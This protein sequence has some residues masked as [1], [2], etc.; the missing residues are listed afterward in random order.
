MTK[1]ATQHDFFVVPAKE[2]ERGEWLVISEQDE[3]IS[4]ESVSSVTV[5]RGIKSTD[6]RK[7]NNSC[8]HD[9]VG[10]DE[11]TTAGGQFFGYRAPNR[12][13]NLDENKREHCFNKSPRVTISI[14]HCG[15]TGYNAC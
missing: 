13:M 7:K 12:T 15:F 2:K 14:N 8:N 4:N 5:H 11:S 6:K 10:D 3:N 9:C 1:M